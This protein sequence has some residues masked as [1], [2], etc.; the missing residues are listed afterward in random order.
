M[1]DDSRIKELLSREKRT[2]FTSNP[3][4]QILKASLIPSPLGDMIAIADEKALH[5]LEFVDRKNLKNEIEKLVKKTA[6]TIVPG[7]TH[8]LVS[9]EKELHQYF[10]GNLKNFITAMHV[11]GTPFQKQVWAELQKI[12]SGQ[13]CSYKDIAHRIG[14][15]TGSRA[16]AQAIGTNHL[17]IIIPCHRVIATN[18]KLVLI[19]ENSYRPRCV[20]APGVERSQIGQ[21]QEYGPDL[22]SL[23]PG[24]LTR[25][26]DRNF[27]ELAL[28]GYSGGISR[29]EW[30]LKHE[31]GAFEELSSSLTPNDS[32]F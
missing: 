31:T 21:Y 6:S 27:R 26:G 25:G 15:P 3:D 19:P 1:N 10:T 16:V 18:G 9:I 11:L 23:N 30:L 7:S 4:G 8:P 14:K 28:G 29:K 2:T 12:P 5:L 24:A 13:T 22:R 17:A 32:D 20:K